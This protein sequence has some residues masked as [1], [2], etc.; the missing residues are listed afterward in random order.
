[1]ARDRA[2]QRASVET[3]R[4][5]RARNGDCHDARRYEGAAPQGQGYGDGMRWLAFLFLLLVAGAGVA[6]AVTIAI[7]GGQGSYRYK[8]TL[9]VDTPDGV[10]IGSSVVEVQFHEVSFPASGVMHRLEGEAL[11]IDLGPGKR[12]LIALLTNQLHPKYGDKE[13]WTRDGG[14]RTDFLLRLYGETPSRDSVLKNVLRLARLRG[15]HVIG[16][17]ELPDLVTFANVNDPKSVIEVDAS[18]LEATLGPGIK[19]R[20]ITLESTDDPVTKG[21][22]AK[23][24]WLPEYYDKMLGGPRYRIDL[25]LASKLNTSNFWQPANY[26]KGN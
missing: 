18:D 5:R 6:L 7:W 11:Y 8:L 15:P 12:P 13:R 17:T 1:M 23:L 4:A 20:E 9:A 25:V 14:P 2:I 3:S 19:W 26:K 21:I 10:K 24:P 22:E 16:P